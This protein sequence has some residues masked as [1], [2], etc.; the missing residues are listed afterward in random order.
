MT[1]CPS[2]AAVAACDEIILDEL[3]ADFELIQSFAVSAAEAALRGDRA[4][5]RL[6]LR[7][8]LRDVFRHAVSVH[9][10]LSAEPEARAA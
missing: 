7:V 4:E 1:A 6:R 8:Q 2:P 10:L 3:F 5:I 9:D